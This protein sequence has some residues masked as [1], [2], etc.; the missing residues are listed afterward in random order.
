MNPAWVVLLIVFVLLC[1][2]MCLSLLPQLMLIIVL[3]LALAGL[4]IGGV[5][6]YLRGVDR[7]NRNSQVVGGVLILAAIIDLAYLLH[8]FGV[9]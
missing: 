2:P 5:L 9:L 8:L 7:N 3:I 6:L 1:L 4:G